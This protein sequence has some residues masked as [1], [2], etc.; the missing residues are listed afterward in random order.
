MNKFIHQGVITVGVTI[1]LTALS[2][3]ARA[4]LIVVDHQPHNTGGLASDTEFFDPNFPGTWQR[5]ADDFTLATPATIVQVNWWGFYNDDNPPSSETMRVRFYDSRPG[6]GLPDDNNIIREEYFN[7]P[8]RTWTG[9][10]VLT[11]IIPREFF[12]E[13]ELS[14]PIP[15]AANTRYWLEVVQIGAPDS[16]FRW[17]FSLA[18]LN[19]QAFINQTTGDWRQTT[20][21]GDT[22]FQLLI[23]E[24]TT[25]VL[26]AL[27]ILTILTRRRISL[28]QDDLRFE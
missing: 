24:P 15:L 22:A 28:S 17:E 13:A 10:Q 9:R 14:T 18:N 1:L 2:T 3:A 25:S 27:V 4:G 5:V 20:I 11:G 8:S 21:V 16:R 26:L 7:N 23:P 6:N 19:G 12:F